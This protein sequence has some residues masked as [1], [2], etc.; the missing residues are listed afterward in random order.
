MTSPN[1]GPDETRARVGFSP[2]R[3]HSLA[4][5]RIEPPPSLACPI[6]TSPAATAAAD[7]P[8]EPPVERLVSHGFRVGPYASG[9]VVGRMPSS[10]VFVLPTVTRPAPPEAGRQRGVL[11][12]RPV[13]VLEERHALVERVA[14]RVRG[15]VLEDEGDA[16]QRPVGK[17]LRRR[18]GTGAA[19]TAA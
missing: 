12:L 15:Q 6:G 4:G 8:L 19:R 10:G 3:P 9:S 17:P 14:R 1:S 18:L 13:A 2:T 7:P 5:M 11:G 16:A